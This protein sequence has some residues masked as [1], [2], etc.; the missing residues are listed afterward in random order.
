MV[1]VLE[2]G[3]RDQRGDTSGHDDVVAQQRPVLETSAQVGADIIADAVLEDE[4]P[5]GLRLVKP[6][7]VDVVDHP[8]SG[9]QLEVH[10]AV[11]QEQAGVDEIALPL[12]LARTEIR[13]QALAVDQVNAE[14]LDCLALPVT[15]I[16][17]GKV[18]VVQDRIETGGMLV[19]GVV[20]AGR[21][22]ELGAEADP[23]AVVGEFHGGHLGVDVL[24]LVGQGVE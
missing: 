6:Q 7:E 13:N 4:G 3:S 10:S 23:V 18:R 22:E 1:Q 24:V 2:A 19:I 9:R 8:Q 11:D 16:A 12:G 15:E 17:A 20:V 14:Q 21:P 5:Q